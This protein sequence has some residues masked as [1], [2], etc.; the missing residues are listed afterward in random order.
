MRAKKSVYDI[1]KAVKA[2]ELSSDEFKISLMENGHI[3]KKTSYKRRRYDQDV[4]IYTSEGG[5]YMTL[6]ALDCSDP[7]K[8][9]EKVLKKL[10]G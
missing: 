6:T 3:V 10:N 7:W 5:H 9:S 4:V 2:G 1:W 8:E